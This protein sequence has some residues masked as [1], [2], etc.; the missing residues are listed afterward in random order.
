MNEDI[1]KSHFKSNRAFLI[2]NLK[3]GKWNFKNQKTSQ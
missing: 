1:K 2:K 3:Y